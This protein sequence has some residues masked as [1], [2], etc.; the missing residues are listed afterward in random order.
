LIERIFN[1]LVA[2]VPIV[3]IVNL[4]AGIFILVFEWPLPLFSD[5]MIYRAF[6]LRFAVYP[7]IAVIA[8]IQYQCTNASFYL[9]IA[10]A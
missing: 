5:T 4:V 10:T 1:G 7:I 2:P 8:L 9:L 6:S 3:Q